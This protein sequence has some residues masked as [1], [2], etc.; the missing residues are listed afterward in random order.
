[1]KREKNQGTPVGPFCYLHSVLYCIFCL[2]M[3]DEQPNRGGGTCWTVK[4]LQE[5]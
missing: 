1:M 3:V 5:M 4:L 2:H